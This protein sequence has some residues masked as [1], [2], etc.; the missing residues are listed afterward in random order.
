MIPLNP[1]YKGG[2]F[3]SSPLSSSPLIKGGQGGYKT[4][5]HRERE[6]AR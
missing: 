3:V 2:L 5:A 6:L 1:P 4:V